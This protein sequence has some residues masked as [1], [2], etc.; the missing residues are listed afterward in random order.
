[1][2]SVTLLVKLKE[3]WKEIN[4]HPY[5]V[6]FRGS[7]SE[8]DQHVDLSFI[9]TTLD[10]HG[11]SDLNDFVDHIMTLFDNARKINIA[12]NSLCIAATTLERLFFDA[13]ARRELL[14]SK[15]KK[16]KV[17]RRRMRSSFI[18]KSHFRGR[19]IR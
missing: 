8:N 3:V 2:S 17:Y 5:A 14:P 9:K 12:D 6:Y 11:Y 4:E 18:Y 10:N 19:R 1:M 16:N 7:T 15:T 13:L